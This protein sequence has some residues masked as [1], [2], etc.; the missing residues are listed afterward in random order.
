MATGIAEKRTIVLFT[1]T[2][3]YGQGETFLHDEIGHLSDM[4]ETIYLFPLY[5]PKEKTQRIVPN[6]VFI[7]SP[8]LRCDHKSIKG[9]LLY[10]IINFAPCCMIFK[11]F[12]RKKVWKRITNLRIFLSYALMLRAMLA[13]KRVIK[14]LSGYLNKENTILYCYW[15]DKSAMTLPYLKQRSSVHAPFVVRFHGSDIFE[16]AKGF[17]PFRESIY[18]SIDYA[19]P[20]SQTGADYI[21]RKYP[22]TQPA[23][24]AVSHLGSVN[25]FTLNNIME[26]AHEV[27][28]KENGQSFRILSCSN[29]IPLKRVEIIAKAIMI[30]RSKIHNGYAGIPEEL[31]VRWLHI[32]DG[33]LKEDIMRLCGEESS[34]TTARKKG[35][36]WFTIT[37]ALP[38][39]DVLEQYLNYN[40]EL[41]VHTSSSEG[42]PVS[43]MEAMS[44]GVP[45]MA[46]DVG[47]TG[48]LFCDT[49]HDLLLPENI[50]PELLAERILNYITLPMEKKEEIGT[51]MRNLWEAH[52]NADKN[53]SDFVKFLL[54]IPASK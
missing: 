44:F 49:C 39:Q 8:L 50:T 17:L 21:Q 36:S 18:S 35:E 6:N 45:V 19:C 11:E 13:N 7:K 33:P 43:I 37:G 47:G 9:L 34:T 1:N 48:E 29:I 31:H 46:T 5:I 20:V 40:P 12:F 10:G 41:F 54:K 23:H 30:A 26:R 52:W 14:E 15:G 3:P 27:A 4:A 16:E 38:H 53:Y 42:I 32:G 25:L 28:L 2:Y 22:D 24:I 51:L